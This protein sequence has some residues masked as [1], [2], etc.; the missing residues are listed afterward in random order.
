[1][2]RYPKLSS[3]DIEKILIKHGFK[4]V[5]RREATNNLK[6]L[7]KGEKEELQFLLIERAF[8]QRRLKA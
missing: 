3:K 1:M 8:I 5:S 6:A 7:L 2:P 4:F